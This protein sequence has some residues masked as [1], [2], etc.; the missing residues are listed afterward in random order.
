VRH[1]SVLDEPEQSDVAGN[2]T[3]RD[4][5]VN[6]TYP[7]VY[8]YDNRNLLTEYTQGTINSGRTAITG[9]P[10]NSGTYMMAS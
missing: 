4:D 6:T 9:T 7:Q 3:Y 10:T 2:V 1:R 5:L 8:T